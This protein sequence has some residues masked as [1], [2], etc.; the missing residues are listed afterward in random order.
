M[1]K[2]FVLA[3]AGTVCQFV[4]VTGY[5]SLPATEEATLIFSHDKSKAFSV[6]VMKAFA[7]AEV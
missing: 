3:P 5:T 4:A 2:T 1:Q 7:G 6:P